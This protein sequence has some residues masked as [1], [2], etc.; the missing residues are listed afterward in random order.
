MIKL[1]SVSSNTSCRKARAWLMEN[2]I[3]FVERNLGD[4]PLKKQDIKEILAQSENGIWDIV[5]I[6]SKAYRSLDVDIE[7]LNLNAILELFEANQELI[8][9]PI[10]MDDYRL[11]VGFNQD[12]IRMFVPKEVRRHDLMDIYLSTFK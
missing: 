4:K 10:L 5:S 3:A 7:A 12:E 6:R 11:Q 2:N 9:V 8:R 1:Y